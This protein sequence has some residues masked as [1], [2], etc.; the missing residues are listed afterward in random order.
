MS[1]AALTQVGPQQIGQVYKVDDNGQQ[2]VAE[3]KNTV[4]NILDFLKNNPLFNLFRVNDKIFS[5]PIVEGTEKERAIDISQL[6]DDVTNNTMVFDTKGLSNTAY[7]SA[8][9]FIDGDK[10]GEGI[11]NYRGYNVKDLAEKTSFPEVAYLL[12]NDKLPNAEELKKFENDVKAGMVLEPAVLDMVKKLPK[13]VH[14]MNILSAAVAALEG[15]TPDADRKD[16]AKNF[17]LL[18]GKVLALTACLNR[19]TIQGG[20]KANLPAVD[21]EKDVVDNFMRMMFGGKVFENTELYAIKK[22]VIDKLLILHADHEQ[23]CSTFTGRV[24][25]SGGAGPFASVSA[26]V[27]ALYGPSHGG[28]NQAVLEQLEAIRKID[29]PTIDE[30]IAVAIDAFKLDNDERQKAKSDKGHKPQDHNLKN[31]TGHQLLMGF[32]HRVYKTRDPRATVIEDTCKKLFDSSAF[33]STLNPKTLELLEI[34]QKLEAK[35]LNE[36]YFKSRDLYPNVDFYSGIVYKAL[37]IPTEMFTPMFAAGRTPGW[38]THMQEQVK[39]CK[40]IIRPRQVYTGKTIADR[41]ALPIDKQPGI[42]A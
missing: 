19:K 38:L 28:A 8:V 7:P 11:L 6:R 17:A 22:R 29:K 12:F 1:I 15:F 10:T 14:P 23:N 13:S 37:G 5:M 21:P 4:A 9:T 32:G 41:A 20:E 31:L 26:A 3:L 33:K 27:N 36:E 35:A 40:N 30:K 18:I 2:I 42:A 16:Y 34:A 39:D 25:A 24:T